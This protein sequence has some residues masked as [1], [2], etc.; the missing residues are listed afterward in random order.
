MD[1]KSSSELPDWLDETAYSHHRDSVEFCYENGW[2]TGLIATIEPFFQTWT[3]NE[4]EDESAE[5]ADT[6]RGYEAIE[7]DGERINFN[8]YY[9]ELAQQTDINSEYLSGRPINTLDVLEDVQQL[10]NA[11]CHRPGYFEVPPLTE[12]GHFNDYTGDDEIEISPED[13]LHL[14]EEILGIP[15]EDSITN[16]GPEEG[17]TTFYPEEDSN[18]FY[19]QP[20]ID[21]PLHSDLSESNPTGLN[22][23]N[24][25]ASGM[26]HSI[27]H[28]NLNELHRNGYTTRYNPAQPASAILMYN[29]F[30]HR[31]PDMIQSE[32]EDQN[33]DTEVLPEEQPQT[34]NEI[35]LEN[36]IEEEIL[37][38]ID[39]LPTSA[40]PNALENPRRRLEELG[41]I[42]H[43]LAHDVNFYSEI[44][45]IDIRDN[46]W[47]GYEIMHLM[48]D[49]EGYATNEFELFG[50]EAEQQRR[51][52]PYMTRSERLSSWPTN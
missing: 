25:I 31:L 49:R 43:S 46:I 15:E 24:S 20:Q 9:S 29:W 52:R 13:I 17:E 14:Y 38:Q 1:A 36:W 19:S 33:L 35:S 12:E 32:Y 47:H 40:H 34:E 8:D 22:H 7:I 50:E 48:S 11:A 18:E 3:E 41:E 23:L 44:E 51:A 16:S 5:F 30:E 26:Y 4:L 2:A 27:G 6:G 37:S 39:I 42:R 28:E 45:D 10:R 21:G